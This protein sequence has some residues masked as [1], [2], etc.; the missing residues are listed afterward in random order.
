MIKIASIER[1]AKYP[2]TKAELE[3][4]ILR[5]IDPS[6]AD[7]ISSRVKVNF[8]Y[9]M[10]GGYECGYDSSDNYRWEPY[11]FSGLT[12]TITEKS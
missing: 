5:E 3:A 1:T 7:G 10:S 8:E 6:M 4:L 9:S 2:I 11:V 12:V